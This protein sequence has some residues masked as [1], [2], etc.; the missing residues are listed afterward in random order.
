MEY[1]FKKGFSQVKNKDI[2]TVRQQIM[3]T[4]GITTR[5]GFHLRLTG[6]IE[7]RVSEAEKIAE[8]FARYGI[9]DIWGEE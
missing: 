3:D 9:H 4:L 5:A 7:P 1:S 8:V 2:R 6:N